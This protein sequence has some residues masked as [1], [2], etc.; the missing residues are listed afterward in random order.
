MERK[1]GKGGLPSCYAMR[2][3]VTA[4]LALGGYVFEAREGGCKFWIF[5]LLA[6]CFSINVSEF[7]FLTIIAD[8]GRRRS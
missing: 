5:A 4:V 1:K 2:A 6:L 3:P 8:C 7:F